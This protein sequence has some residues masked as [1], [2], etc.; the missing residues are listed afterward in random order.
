MGADSDFTFLFLWRLTALLRCLEEHLLIQG[1]SLR[2]KFAAW[3]MAGQSSLVAAEGIPWGHPV[4][5]ES[6]YAALILQT[7]VD[8]GMYD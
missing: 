5:Q 6:F 1:P 8:K 4:P 3:T 7:V 2:S